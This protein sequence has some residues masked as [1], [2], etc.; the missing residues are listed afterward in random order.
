MKVEID[1]PLAGLPA[2]RKLSHVVA[3]YPQ[4]GDYYLNGDEWTEVVI[5][6]CT[7]RIVARFEPIETWRPATIAD[8]IRAL[9]GEEIQVRAK[10]AKSETRWW[11]GTLAGC[12]GVVVDNKPM[13]PWSIRSSGNGIS[14]YAICEVREFE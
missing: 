1:V 9:Q 12:S 10:D 11:Y 5:N 3:K 13:Y 4:E 8:A 2:D 14:T 6:F 7:T